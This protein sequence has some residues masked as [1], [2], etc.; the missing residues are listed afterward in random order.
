M[1]KYLRT[2]GISA[3]VEELPVSYVY[4][5]YS[6]KGGYTTVVGWTLGKNTAQLEDLKNRVNLNN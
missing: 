3:E 5:F 4:N 2:S 6:F 1:A